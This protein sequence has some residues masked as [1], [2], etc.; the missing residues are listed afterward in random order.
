MVNRRKSDCGLT[1]DGV[2]AINQEL[3][4]NQGEDTSLCLCESGGKAALIAC[5]DGCGGAGAKRYPAADNWSGARLASHVSSDVTCEWFRTNQIARLGTQGYSA[6]QIAESLKNALSDRVNWTHEVL[7]KTGPILKGSLSK[8]LPT[9]MTTAVVENIDEQTNR[10]LFLWVGDS[11]G[12]L[13]GVQGMKQMTSDDVQG[14]L[15][16][17]ENLQ[18]DGVLSNVISAN[19]EFKVHVREIFIHEPCVIITATDGCFSY[20]ISPIEFE[21]AILDTLCASSGLDDWEKRLQVR[22]GEVAS[23]DYTMQALIIGFDSF[24]NLKSSFMP[25]VTE[26]RK[27]FSE[28][29]KQLKFHDDKNGMARLWQEY[30]KFY[31]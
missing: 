5:F 6:L 21:E 10:C 15:D 9:T 28:P 4:K 12:F 23:D 7:T 2:I 19:S 17:L 31:I 27:R 11:R 16:P 26:F 20:F 1:I 14:N 29:L 24:T 30:K 3:R 22:I 13:F 18:K 8:S 25:R